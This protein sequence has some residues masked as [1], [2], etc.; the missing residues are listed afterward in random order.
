[1]PVVYAAAATGAHGLGHEHAAQGSVGSVDMTPQCSIVSNMSNMSLTSQS[2]TSNGHHQHQHQHALSHHAH[3]QHSSISASVRAHAGQYAPPGLTQAPAVAPSYVP[4][5]QPQPQ[6]Q[7]AVIDMNDAATL[8]LYSQLLLFRDDPTR[9]TCAFS[10]LLTHAQRTVLLLLANKLGLD[11]IEADGIVVVGRIE[12]PY[13]GLGRY[14]ESARSS[15]H[16]QNTP[17]MG[18]RGIQ[19]QHLSISTNITPER[20]L[21]TP[22]ALKATRSFS[23]LRAAMAYPT[24]TESAS[25]T[26]VAGVNVSAGGTPTRQPKGPDGSKGFV[27]MKKGERAD[28]ADNWRV[29]GAGKKKEGSEEEFVCV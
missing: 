15:S 26:M 22:S 20:S 13:A 1:M 12:A 21:A 29:A 16:V 5:P 8:A 9:T 6:A 18:S 17:P 25:S 4:Q 27:G 3:H 28:R 23:D 11:A 7:E 10:P 2:S 14:E 19:H 24:P